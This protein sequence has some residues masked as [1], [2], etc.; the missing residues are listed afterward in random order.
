[1]KVGT[2]D[3]IM[4]ADEDKIRSLRERGGDFIPFKP[5]VLKTIPFVYSTES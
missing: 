1:M 3:L 2:E 4:R 5:Y